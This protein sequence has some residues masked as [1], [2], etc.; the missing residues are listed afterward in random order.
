MH[1]ILH[2]GTTNVTYHHSAG[3]IQNS[4]KDRDG[5]SVNSKQK[6]ENEC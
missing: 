2:K 1:S 4:F 6:E 3:F 5:N